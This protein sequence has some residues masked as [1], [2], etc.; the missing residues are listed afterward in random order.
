MTISRETQAEILRLFHAEKWPI[1]TIASQLLLHHAVIERVLAHEGVPARKLP[2]PSKLDPY[3]GFVEDVLRR[4]PGLCAS[5]V[6]W[7]TKERG[8]AGSECHLRRLV[9]RLR[10]A[11][12]TE[13]Y[14]RLK[15]LPGEQAQV[16]WA[17]FGKI[18]IGRAE[19]PLVAF[20]IVLSYSRRV[21]LCFFL[22]QQTENFLRGHQAAFAH[23]GGSARVLLYDNLKS[24]V[25]ER[26]GGAIRFHPL[27][28]AFSTHHR[29]E[30]R[31]VAVARGN[32][33]GRVER[34]IEYIRTAFFSARSWT[35]LDD[36]NRQA[37]EWCDTQAFERPWPEDRSQSVR[38]AFEREKDK[39]LPLPAENFPSDERREVVVGKT[40]YVRFDLNDYSV[41]HPLVRR[42]LT[43]FASLTRVR[44]LDGPR[45]VALHV[46][47][48][49]KGAVI[50]DKAHIHALV[51][52]KHA[53]R[54]HRGFA[55]LFGAVPLCE[56]FLKTLAQRGE[57]LGAATSRLLVMLDEFG[58]GE[59]KGAV[60]LA[61]EKDVPNYHAVRQILEQKRRARGA[62]PP[63]PVRLP[64]DPRIKDLWVRPHPLSSYDG[65]AKQ[66]ALEESH[67]EF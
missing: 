43:L 57:N 28:T 45:V 52:E 34:T 58:P 23:W 49:E 3:R 48:F 20:V 1:G 44:I 18:T 38:E 40:P 53:A 51:E 14:L 2:R 5:R 36:L 64:D 59:L 31:P 66:D 22:G 16:D 50:E 61:L 47:S 29:F 39:L 56:E 10:P 11:K 9:A 35:D 46:R 33:K 32:E 17:H 12:P 55:R 4:W 65:L 54:K 62:L 60:E 42:T 26:V 19:R 24:V 8:Y 21:F 41:P 15:T 63:I 30:A 67:E 7:M 13:A 25:I 37:L 6:Y 27:I